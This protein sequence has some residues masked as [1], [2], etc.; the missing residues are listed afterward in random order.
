MW[1]FL[2]PPPCAAF[3]TCLNRVR[4]SCYCQKPSFIH[5]SIAHRN[6]TVKV[7]FFHINFPWLKHRKCLSLLFPWANLNFQQP[8]RNHVPTEMACLLNYWFRSIMIV[9][10]CTPPTY[11]AYKSGLKMD[12]WLLFSIIFCQFNYH[13]LLAVDYK[14]H[15]NPQI[16]MHSYRIFFHCSLDWFFTS[17][18]IPVSF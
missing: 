1:F 14:Q 4:T 16:R 11:Q 18:A 5:S 13:L 6:L 12:W 10:R 3:F 9:E 7:T 17:F 8:S 2:W 15:N